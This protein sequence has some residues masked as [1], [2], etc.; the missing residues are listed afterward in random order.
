MRE[1]PGQ[2]AGSAVTIRDFRAAAGPGRTVPYVLAGCPGHML[3]LEEAGAEPVRVPSPVRGWHRVWLGF[4][5]PSSIRLRLAGEPAFRWVD[6]SVRWSGGAADG[7]EVLWRCADLTGAAFEVLPQLAFRRHDA[8]R[9]QLAYIRLEPAMPEAPGDRPT[10]TAGAVIDGHEMLGAYSPRSADEVR[11]LVEPFA[12]SDFGRV[13]FG[14]TVTTMRLTYLSQVGQWLGQGQPQ[15]SLHTETNRRCAAALETGQRAGYDPLDVLID[16]CRHL[17][18]ELW[19]DFRIQQDYPVD[20][21]GGI[22]LDFNAPL[23]EQH[24]EWRHVDRHGQV[25]SHL[26]SHFHPGWEQYK[27]DLL[28]E[29]ARRGPAGIHLNLMCEMGAIWDFEPGAAARCRQQYGADPLAEGDP[30]QEWYRFRCDHLTGFMRRL[31]DQT[32]RIGRERGRRIP[33]AVQVSGDWAIL[34]SGKKVSAVSQNFLAGF[35]I[36]CW[37]REGLVDVVSPSFRRTY[38]PMFLDHLWDELGEGRQRVAVVPSIGQHDNAVFP[39][40]YEWSLYF[41]DEGR[42]AAGLEP[43]GELD[44]WRVLREAHD[45]YQQ[46]AD[47]V[48]VWEMG[49]APVRLDRWNVL[50]QIGDRD[51]L[52]REF[53]GRIRGLMAA[54]A[55]PLRFDGVGG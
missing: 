29:L 28:A 1:E 36:G 27:L 49:H 30:P 43:L 33:I 22:G 46:G 37:A 31:R 18:L 50:K 12:E 23:T 13:H 34:R 6:S 52:R 26:F 40:G 38:R 8:R 53:G 7:E 25:C 9:S 16:H 45:L 42:N 3:R 48:D 39:R 4:A 14:C 24:P 10:R 55:H 17:G 47:A 11:S 44:A 20:Y 5:G 51:L 15:E 2:A 35:D 54:P 32:D 21:G 19:A 41:T